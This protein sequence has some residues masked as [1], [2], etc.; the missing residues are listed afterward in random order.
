MMSKYLRFFLAAKAASLLIV[1]GLLAGCSEPERKEAKP[2]SGPPLELRV[3]FPD[4]LLGYFTEAASALHAANPALADGTRIRIRGDSDN[5]VRLANLIADGTRKDQLWLGPRHLI[6]FANSAVR[7]LGSRHSECSALFSV[8]LVAASAGSGSSTR[9]IS[10]NIPSPLLT[11]SGSLLLIHADRVLSSVGKSLVRPVGR[12]GLPAATTLRIYPDDSTAAAQVRQGDD[13]LSIFGSWPAAGGAL[14]QLTLE[15]KLPE[16]EY[17]LCISSGPWITTVQRAAF[18]EVRRIFA[19][20]E[21]QQIAARH[22]FVLPQSA[23]LPALQMNDSLQAALDRWRELRAPART[24]VLIDSSASMSG[25][26]LTQAIASAELIADTTHDQT[27]IGL[28]SVGNEPEVIA[29]LDR[30]RTQF[31]KAL[32]TLIPAGGTRLLDALFLAAGKLKFEADPQERHVIAAFID[33]ADLGSIRSVD[34]V[35]SA[36]ESVPNLDVYFFVIQQ[37]AKDLSEIEALAAK[38]HAPMYKSPVEQFGLLR[39]KLAALMF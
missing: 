7:G 13:Q 16:L 36:L 12:A 37:G 5:S 29:P 31:K 6:E 20:P 9:P 11:S 2:P 14:P 1:T 26:P 18:S 32:P 39:V 25:E 24:M 3:Y 17:V 19:T 10:I 34:E 22:G 35:Q 23:A 27:E 8:P 30:R 38:L 28:V 15:P 33:S 21:L 4:E